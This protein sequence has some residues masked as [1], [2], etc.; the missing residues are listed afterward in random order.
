MC[1]CEK[2]GQQNRNLKQKY[3][4]LENEYYALSEKFNEKKMKPES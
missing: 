1:L 4:E 2:I 3:S